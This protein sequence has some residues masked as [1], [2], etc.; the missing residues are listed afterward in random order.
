MPPKVTDKS[1][2]KFKKNVLSI[3]NKLKIIINKNLNVTSCVQIKLLVLKIL[4][5]TSLCLNKVKLAT[6]RFLFQ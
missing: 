2:K 5:T 3:N 1:K 4:E 6:Q